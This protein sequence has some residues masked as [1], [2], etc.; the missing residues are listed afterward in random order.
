MPEFSYKAITASG[1]TR[2]GTLDASDKTSAI[3]IL[4]KKT[5]Q[6]LSITEIKSAKSNSKKKNFG[7]EKKTKGK[8]PEK[9]KAQKDK[10]AAKTLKRLS[11]KEVLSLNFLKRLHELHASGLA[12]GDA[13]KL[14]SQRLSE[15]QLKA[16]C[17][18]VWKE[19]SEGRNL[20]SA[21]ASLPDV[22]PPSITFV[23]EA[24]EQTGELNPILAKIISYMEE[25]REIRAKVL[26]SMAYPIFVIMI[27]I[28]VVIGVLT[29]LMPQIDNMLSQLG[30]ERNFAA[31]LLIRS[32]EFLK[33]TGPFILAGLGIF[34]L[35]FS[36]WRKTDTGRKV[37]DAFMLKVPLIGPITLY[38]NLFQTCNLL[39]TL[40]ASGLTTTEAL[41]LTERTIN[42]LD[43][44]QRFNT[45]RSQVNEGIGFTTALRQNKFMPDLPLDILT[46]GENT[47]NLVHSLG[48]I[49]KSFRVQ[50][51]QKMDNM[52]V[53]VSSGA[54]GFAFGIVAM[55]AY[56]MVSSI[57]SVSGSL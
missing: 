7:K 57:F 14:L 19:I 25:R 24:G 47:G 29:F 5:K 16:V 45:T 13:I 37:T 4:K 30:G 35:S 39:G 34:G 26:G 46:V 49:T 48:E 27:A 56:V 32:G 42:N 33:V 53:L 3:H 38:S 54:L 1:R 23:I 8:E 21:M 18:H 41:R 20:A 31:D 44:R 50:L 6:I 11:S 40:L 2:T 22:F 28:A 17:A 12:L 15:P 9:T 43:L 52:T 36:Q 51:S 55:V 10:Q